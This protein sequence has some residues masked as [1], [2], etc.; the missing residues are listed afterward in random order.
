MKTTSECMRRKVAGFLWV[1]SLKIQINLLRWIGTA[2]C[3]LDNSCH[4]LLT[5]YGLC[6]CSDLTHVTGQIHAASMW[7]SM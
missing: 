6:F 5:E 4:F 3:P 7:T 2:T 1:L